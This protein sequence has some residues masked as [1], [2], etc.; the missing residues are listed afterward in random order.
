MSTSDLGSTDFRLHLLKTMDAPDSLLTAALDDLGSSKEDML[1]R[2][3][4]VHR[5]LWIRDGGSARNILPMLD[6]VRVPSPREEGSFAFS[7]P[8]WKDFLYVVSFDATGDIDPALNGVGCGRF[9]V[10]LWGG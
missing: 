7:L 9:R 1:A 2:S 3:A 8:V 10:G 4:D 6:R 5:A